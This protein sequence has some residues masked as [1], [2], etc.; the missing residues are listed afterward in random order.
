MREMRRVGMAEEKL[1]IFFYE[2][3]EEEA[4]RLLAHAAAVGVR[5]GCSPVT[6]QETGHA[7][8][9]AGVVSLRTQSVI[10]VEWAGRLDGVLSRS[11]GYDHV[12]GWRE[13]VEAAGGKCPALGHL[14]AYCAR[15]VAEQALLLWMA[16]LR[17]LPEQ[18]AQMG[19]FERDGL[20][21]REAEGKTLAV[22]GV[23]RIGHEICKIGKGLGMEVVGVDVV[24]KHGDVAYAEPGEAMEK[25]DVVACAMNLT[26]ENR[27][28][29]SREFLARAKRRPVLV[30][31]ARGECTPA[32]EVETAL[33]AGWIRGAG[34]DVFNEESRLAPALR[35]GDEL[36]LTEDNR[37]LL[38]L[39]GR[40]DVIC[41]PHNAFNTAEAV[42]RKAEQSVRSYLHFRETGAFLWEVPRRG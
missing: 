39:M 31:V 36:G 33:E 26:E 21:G 3:F 5:A 14:P 9:P 22:F 16:L 1:D 18:E 40:K 10:P 38:R 2:A 25:A 11:T 34:L 13:R 4:E 12:A 32:A 28:Y 41:T 23:G 15:A 7:A 24:K 27:G 8:P 35:R 29:F 20:T 42:E 17:K 6:I 19:R 30:N 37:A